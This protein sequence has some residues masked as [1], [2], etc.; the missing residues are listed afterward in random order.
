MRTRRPVRQNALGTEHQCT[1]SV[2]KRLLDL[3][4]DSVSYYSV[5]TILTQEIEHEEDL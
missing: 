2:N 1:I 4:K 5:P 3:T